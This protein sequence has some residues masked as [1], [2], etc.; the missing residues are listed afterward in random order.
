MGKSA[1]DPLLL[2][3]HPALD[4][5]NTAAMVNGILTDSLASDADVLRWLAA[6]GFPAPHNN[7]VVT[8]SL[9]TAAVTFR[10]MLRDAVLQKKAGKPISWRH[11]NALLANCTSHL[12]VVSRE[13]EPHSERRWTSDTPEQILGPL[14]EAAVNLLVTDDFELVRH[15]EDAKCVLWFYDRTKSHRRRWCSPQTC[16]NR[17]KV[18]AYRERQ[19]AR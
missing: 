2:A 4:F 15:C 7:T 1:A 10:E 3:D 9:R 18:A 17:N 19:Q 14:I 13:G 6:A 11:W 12:V 16:G 5:L 8:G